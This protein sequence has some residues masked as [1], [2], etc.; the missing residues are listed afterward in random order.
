MPLSRVRRI[1]RLDCVTYSIVS[2]RI[3]SYLTFIISYRIVSFP[4][5]IASR[6]RACASSRTTPP[7]GIV[8]TAVYLGVRRSFNLLKFNLAPAVT[9]LDF[10]VYPPKLGLG[11][12][13]AAIHESSAAAR[14]GPCTCFAAAHAHASLRSE[15]SECTGLDDSM[16]PVCA[17]RGNPTSGCFTTEASARTHTDALATVS[18]GV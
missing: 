3:L 12:A 6:A 18:I 15:G 2:Y 16:R 14:C 10:R 13:L 1:F 11:M 9:S 8:Q 17:A 7:E 5:A 4:T